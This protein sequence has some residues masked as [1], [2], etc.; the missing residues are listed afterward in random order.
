MTKEQFAEMLNVRQYR[1]EIA[2][3][4]SK[5]AQEHGLLV[6]FG[7]SDDLM[8]FRGV[9]DDEIGAWD[10]A[11]AYLTTDKQNR[12][13][14]LQVED[15]DEDNIDEYRP[16]TKIEAE[17]CPEN[18][19]GEVIASWLIKTDIPHVT[20]DITEDGELYCRGIVIDEADVLKS[21]KTK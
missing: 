9:L 13:S 10:G 1:N 11:I 20:F 5:L 14:L 8:E 21:M 4:E 19:E 12:L 15:D 2:E 7:A 17:W 16:F 6:V 3:T 18:E